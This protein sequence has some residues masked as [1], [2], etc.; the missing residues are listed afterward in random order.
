MNKLELLKAGR[1]KIA[2][3]WCQGHYAESARVMD[4]YP[5]HQMQ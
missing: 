5:N 2:E 1:E 3:G 4:I